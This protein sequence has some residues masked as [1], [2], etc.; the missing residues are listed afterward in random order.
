[1]VLVHYKC[2]P[3]NPRQDKIDLAYESISHETKETGSKLS[4]FETIKAP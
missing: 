1:M 4:S 3:D 2:Y